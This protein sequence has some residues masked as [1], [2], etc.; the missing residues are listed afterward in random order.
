MVRSMSCEPQSVTGKGVLKL[1]NAK[2]NLEVT[3][4][5]N[6]VRCTS[7]LP[8]FQQLTNM[9]VQEGVE[10][11]EASGGKISCKKGCGACCKQL[12]PI[13][14]SEA[15]QLQALVEAMP[16]PRRTEIRNRFSQGRE[17]LIQAGVLQKVENPSARNKEEAAAMGLEYFYMGVPCPFLEE[18][19]CSIHQNRPLACREYLVVSSPEHCANPTRETVHCIAIPAHVS[20]VVKKLSHSRPVPWLPLISALDFAE[21]NP[22][23]SPARPGPEW[24][25]EVLQQL[26]D[27]TPETRASQVNTLS[28]PTQFPPG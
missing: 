9:I 24:F 20:S 19:S 8:L 3:M 5:T 7:M 14:E 6:P 2:I 21:K 25:Q 1:G 13:A 15:Y 28:P 16:E 4:T 10:Q 22:D 12:V 26:K 27:H 11:I 23:Q 17:K 18:E